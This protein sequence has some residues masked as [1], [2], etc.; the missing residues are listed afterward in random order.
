MR[1]EVKTGLSPQSTE[2][3]ENIKKTLNGTEEVTYENETES[4]RIYWDRSQKRFSNHHGDLLIMKHT[5]KASTRGYEIELDESYEFD[6]NGLF[7]YSTSVATNFSSGLLMTYISFPQANDLNPI[8]SGNHVDNATR[9]SN[10]ERRASKIF[11]KMT[12]PQEVPQ[13]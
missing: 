7:M 4:L 1:T 8:S 6:A 2:L 10:L 13:S 9:K 11:E 12:K 3:I 5:L